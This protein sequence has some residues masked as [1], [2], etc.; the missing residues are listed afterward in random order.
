MIALEFIA[1]LVV[2]TAA[3]ALLSY[4]AE[5]LAERY[6]ANFTGSIVL[7][8][9]TTLPEY[10]F[11]IFASIKG[12]YGMAVGSAVGACTLLITLGYGSIILLATTRLSR[13]PV[14]VV[15]L[16]KG[17]RV[18]ALYLLVTALIAFGLAWEGN[19]F[20]LKDAAILILLFFA[21]VVHVAKGAVKYARANVDENQSRQ[22]LLKS[23]LFLLIGGVVVFVASGPFV[24]SMIRVATV[25]RVSPV[26][27]AIILG[28]LASEMPEKITA[29]ITVVR[30]GKLAEISVCNFIGSKVNHNSLL[31]GTMPIIA[32][33][34]GGSSVPG[35]ISLPFIIMTALTVVA[36][37]S[38]SRRRLARWEGVMFT[39]LYVLVVWGAFHLGIGRLPHG[40]G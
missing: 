38:L 10:M 32:V 28:P 9:I 30:D 21:Y 24:D 3:A 4:G 11:V 23:I 7:A 8:I 1:L 33:L 12:E 19:G 16:S 18:D 15:E 13:R 26:T 25:L 6:G 31:L 20:D 37:L 17:T 36:T 35:I 2:L 27:I 34:Q 5:P 39:L 40:P 14:K 22:N 29:Y